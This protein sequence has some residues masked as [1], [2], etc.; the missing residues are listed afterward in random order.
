MADAKQ[1][2]DNAPVTFPIAVSSH[3]SDNAGDRQT[4][5]DW[6]NIVVFGNLH[7]YAARLKKGDRVYIE[8]E[9][10]NNNYDRKIDTEMVKFTRPSSLPPL[11]SALRP[12][13]KRR[14]TTKP[15]AE[16]FGGAVREHC[17]Q[18]TAMNKPPGDWTN[19]RQRPF[20]RQ[21]SRKTSGATL[22]GTGLLCCCLCDF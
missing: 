12:R 15:Q 6:H 2:S 19:R 1:A 17:P 3:W 9:A 10:R 16:S 22:P 5:T 8:A 7:K 14:P 4:R 11:S 13:A 21:R 18:P 20:Q